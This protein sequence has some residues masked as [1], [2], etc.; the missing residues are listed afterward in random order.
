MDACPKC[1]GK[2]ERPRTK[3]EDG[4]EAD[5]DIHPILS[6]EPKP[7]ERCGGCGE[8]ELTA[9]EIAERTKG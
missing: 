8:A 1:G 5:P 6:K 7:C 4:I 9:D 3:E 2:G